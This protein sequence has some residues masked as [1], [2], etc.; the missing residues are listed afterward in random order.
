MTTHTAEAEGNGVA[1]ATEA[2]GATAAAAVDIGPSV[3]YHTLPLRWI[4]LPPLP[5]L[6]SSSSSPQ[7]F[8]LFGVFVVAAAVEVFSKYC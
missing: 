5:L 1:S 6:L 3:L 7:K 4:I 2:K 8:V